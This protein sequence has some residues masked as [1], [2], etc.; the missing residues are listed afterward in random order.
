MGSKKKR[1][2][3][4]K[5]K[6]LDPEKIKK[7]YVG[8]GWSQNRIALHLGVSQR[9]IG[10]ALERLGVPPRPRTV[11]SDEKKKAA[12][13][14]KI[15]KLYIDKGW[16]QIQI[17]SLFGVSK[18]S[19]ANVLKQL[20]VP[21]RP[22]SILYDRKKRPAV[23]KKIK[24]LYANQGLS[25]NEI[26]RRVHIAASTVAEL[27]RKEGIN[28]PKRPTRR[29]PNPEKVKNLYS[30]KQWSRPRIAKHLGVSNRSVKAAL[31]QMGVATR[32]RTVL[33]DPDKGPALVEK[34]KDLYINQRLSLEETARQVHV[35]PPTVSKLLKS[36]G[37]SVPLRP[38][39]KRLPPRRDLKEILHLYNDEGWTAARIAARLGCTTTTIR[40]D[41]KTAGATL[42]NR[43]PLLDPAKIRE[44]YVD[45]EVPAIKIAERFRVGYRTIKKILDAEG[46]DVLQGRPRNLKKRRSSLYDPRL[47]KLEVGESFQI[48]VLEPYTAQEYFLR[49]AK[50]M[51]I[52]ISTQKVGPTALLIT[53]YE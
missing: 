30:E 37:I 36:E 42:R 52:G 19:I 20:G 4:R 41:I 51:N 11:L 2:I 45:Q 49:L 43:T 40:N 3:A 14:Q 7:L 5:K 35:G 13:S 31:E 16:T 24:D 38:G 48:Q 15:K 22:P 47:A 33:K 46:I 53:R 21:Q 8:K 50:G 25:L 29:R 23:I 9:T 6:V 18:W 34:I 10:S 26:A 17:A 12:V 28:V 32:P 39:R 1:S 44:L 27:L